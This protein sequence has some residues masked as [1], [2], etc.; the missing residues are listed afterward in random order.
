MPFSLG[1]DGG[2]LETNCVILDAEGAVVGEGRGGASSALRAG[3][4]AAFDG[5]ARSA[6]EALA[7]SKLRPRHI[8][9]AV[10][11][12]TGAGRR[13]V[14]RKLL[15]YMVE[16]FPQATVHV[17]SDLEI[18]LE[19]AAGA[20]PG[21]VLVAGAGSAAFGRNAAGA[22]AHAGAYGPWIADEGSAYDIG[23]RAVAAVA[24]TRD[25]GGPVTVLAEMIASAL[26]CPSW[27]ALTDRIAANPEDVFPRIFP[28]VVDAAEAEDST[29][30]EIFFSAALGLS[31]LVMSVV[32]SLGL[33]DQEFVLAKAG[34]VFGRS[35]ILEAMLDSVLRS[36][37]PLAKIS[38]LAVSPAT[39]AARMAQRLAEPR[40]A[41]AA[42]GASD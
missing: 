30:R 40:S 7:Q 11:G 34:G 19:A 36:G 21:V 38:N 9:G 28:V 5:I 17:T 35:R 24:R 20:G 8:S 2:G 31:S 41:R 27:Q 1:I 18:T 22:T 25:C 23:R 33:R 26:D 14:A 3:F 4:P 29:A 37:V 12:V 16:Q 13:S 39:G 15:I 32:R 6:A 42:H 10:A